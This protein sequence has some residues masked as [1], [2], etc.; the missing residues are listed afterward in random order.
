MKYKLIIFDL[1][2]T[3]VDAYKAI[4]KSFNYVMRILGYP[5]RS[6]KVIRKAVG[7]G[8]ENLLKPFVKNKDLKRALFLYRRHHKMSL[9]KYTRLYP[10]TLKLLKKIKEKG[11]KVAVASN[12]PTK[13]SQI[14]IKH[15]GL[16]KFIDYILCADKLRYIKPHPYILNKILKYFSIKC[17]KEVLYVGD[18]TIDIQ[19][20]RNANIDTVAISRGSSSKSQLK[21]EKPLKIIDNLLEILELIK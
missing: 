20:G 12:R 11:I 2:G 6:E 9:L 17:K 14:L 4:T 18:M 8:D 15:L 21:K 1:D 7:W 5:L 10:D 16:D 3:L 19:A 13:F